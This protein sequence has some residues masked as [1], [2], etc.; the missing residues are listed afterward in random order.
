[1]RHMESTLMHHN[2]HGGVQMQLNTIG[3]AADR[4]AVSSATIRRLIATAELPIVRVG[5]CVRLREEDV[6]AL[7]ERGCSGSS[8]NQPERER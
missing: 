5:R 1:M 3:Q 8:N 2:N 7:I 4:L 6:Q